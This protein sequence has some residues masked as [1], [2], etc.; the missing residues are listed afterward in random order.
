MNVSGFSCQ[1]HCEFVTR[2]QPARAQAGGSRTELPV[3]CISPEETPLPRWL[4]KEQVSPGRS[5][6]MSHALHTPSLLPAAPRVSP[7]GCF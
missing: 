6:V 3:G 1:V 4:P 5:L 2:T 7:A